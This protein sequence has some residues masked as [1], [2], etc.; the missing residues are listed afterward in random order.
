MLFSLPLQLVA[1]IGGVLLCG[2]LLST[3]TVA[4][5]YT[6]S[7]VLKEILACVLPFMVFAFVF[8]GIVSLKKRA[9]LVLLIMILA[10]FISNIFVAFLVY[11]IMNAVLPLLSYSMQATHTSLQL[12]E[13]LIAFSLPRVIRSEYALLCSIVVGLLCSFVSLPAVERGVLQLKSIIE[14]FL[15]HFFIPFLPL[16]VAGFLLKMRHEGTFVH[17]MQQYGSAVIVI[18]VVQIA[19]LAWLYFLANRFSPADTVRAIINALPSYITAFST[20][21]STATVPV[22][23]ECA[24]KNTNN[25]PLAQVAMPIMANVHLLGDSISTPILALVTMYFFFGTFPPC[26]QYLYF[27]LYFGVSMFAVSGVPGGGILVIIPV[28]ISALGF[29]PDMI[30]IMTTLYLLLDCFGTATNVMGDGALII[31][32]QRILQKSRILI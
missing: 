15:N 20:M 7:I 1:V 26:M 19:Y 12:L 8:N 14:W 11:G 4:F 17:L 5:F 32:L 10:I 13:P 28:L 25:R 18:V 6:I 30:S 21:S 27:V 9:P 24:V 23:I 29:T 22:S 2:S 3:T 16:Y 31:M